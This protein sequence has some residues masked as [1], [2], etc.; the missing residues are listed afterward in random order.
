MAEQ[1]STVFVVDD[2]DAVRDSMRWLV[3]SIGLPVETYASAREF[4]ETHDPNRP[5]CLCA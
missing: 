1:E 2:D 3:E 5:G 4:L